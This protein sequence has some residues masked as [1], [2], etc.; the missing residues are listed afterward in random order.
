MA[1]YLDKTGL[2]YFWEKIKSYVDGKFYSKTGGSLDGD[3]RFVKKEGQTARSIGFGQS[4]TDGT[5]L[6]FSA[7]SL[8]MSGPEG[9]NFS[10]SGKKIVNLGDPSNDNDAVNLEY[11]KARASSYALTENSVGK[12]LTG[13][14]FEGNVYADWVDP[15]SSGGSITEYTGTAYVSDWSGSPPTNTVSIPGLS[16]DVSG[17]I[18]L[19]NNA[20]ETERAVARNANLSPISQGD[21]TVT[22]VADG[23]VPTVNLPIL[24]YYLE[25]V[26]GIETVDNDLAVM[27]SITL[28]S[29]GWSD[30]AQTVSVPIVLGDET[31]QLIQPVAATSSKEEYEQCGVQCIGQTDGNLFFSC[32]EVPNSDLTVYVVITELTSS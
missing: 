29:D 28:T 12:V 3:I 4:G 18:G 23:Q 21:G 5:S 2:S 26:S 16:A 22:L 20:T 14:I 27:S 17:F 31:K 25:N 11:L 7:T 1:N 9:A 24:V 32:S 6:T 10:M 30:N 19:S 13:C 15:P 8:Q